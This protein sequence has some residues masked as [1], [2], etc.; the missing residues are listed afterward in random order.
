MASINCAV[1]AADFALF[2]QGLCGGR[3]LHV[4]LQEEVCCTDIT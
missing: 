2:C 1:A 3:G 4:A